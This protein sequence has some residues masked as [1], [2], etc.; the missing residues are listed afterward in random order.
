[1]EKKHLPPE[2][3]FDGAASKKENKYCA[4]G[5]RRGVELRAEKKS[6]LLFAQNVRLDSAPLSPGRTAAA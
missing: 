3:L 2:K 5:Q 4:G 6:A 1:M